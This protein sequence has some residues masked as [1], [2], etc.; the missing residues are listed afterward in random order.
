RNDVVNVS[1]ESGA[2]H[3]AYGNGWRAEFSESDCAF[4]RPQLNQ[5]RRVESHQY[6]RDLGPL[7]VALRQQRPDNP[8]CVAVCRDRT[9]SAGHA[10]P[11]LRPTAGCGRG[12]W[13]LKYPAPRSIPHLP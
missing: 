13:F 12:W 3:L 4:V 1:S 8:V 2:D 9:E 6:A 10:V 5:R 7:T 11:R